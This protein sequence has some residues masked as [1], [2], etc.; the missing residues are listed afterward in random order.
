VGAEHG[1]RR[2]QPADDIA[3]AAHRAPSGATRAVIM[4]SR[5]ASPRPLPARNPRASPR[6]TG[7]PNKYAVRYSARKRGASRNILAPASPKPDAATL[8]PSTTGPESMSPAPPRPPG[9]GYSRM[10]PK[11]SADA[12]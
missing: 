9:R 2:E 1:E 8:T 10:P 4:A 7:A 11:P 12:T 6:V 5:I 3:P